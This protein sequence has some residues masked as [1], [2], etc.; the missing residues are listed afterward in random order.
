MGSGENGFGKPREGKLGENQ[1]NG[2]KAWG[3]SEEWRESLDSIF[4]E[5]LWREV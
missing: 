3:E 4:A 1:R 2:R 5:K